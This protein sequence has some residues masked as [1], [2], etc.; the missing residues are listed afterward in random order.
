MPSTAFI[1]FHLETFGAVV[2]SISYYIFMLLS[3]LSSASVDSRGIRNT[4]YIFAK[5]LQIVGSA[6]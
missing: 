6:Q 4:P 5:R 1:I 3:Y 2:G